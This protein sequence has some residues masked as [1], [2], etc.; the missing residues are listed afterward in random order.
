MTARPFIKWVGG[1]RQMLP[2]LQ[3]GVPS[4]FGRYF[5]PFVGGG[6]LFFALQPKHAT[7]NDA[8]RRLVR[9]YRGIR[10]D[11]EGVIDWLSSFQYT[12][13]VYERIRLA[14]VD[15]FRDDAQVAAW[16]VYLNKT[17]FNGLYRVNSRGQFNVPIGKYTN[18]TICDVANLEACSAALQ[19]TR[20]DCTDFEESVDAAGPGDL[21]YFDPPYIPASATAS[22]TAYTSDGF[23][24]H[25]QV[26]LAGVALR[27]RVRGVHVLLSNSDTPLTR[28]LYRGWTLQEVSRRGTVS[29]KGTDRK[30]V[31]ELLI[32]GRPA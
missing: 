8:N 15:R 1:K 19:G 10:D 7:L 22:F 18:P 2:Q 20:I 32:S 9:A 3:A 14:E 17:C 21:V 16:L 5:E 23:G 29:C 31:G 11:V 13:E 25:D 30:A 28:A 27:L 6:A 12:P 26:R 24:Y 4:S